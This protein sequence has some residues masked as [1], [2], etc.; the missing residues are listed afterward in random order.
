M[1]YRRNVYMYYYYYVEAYA[2]VTGRVSTDVR[3]GRFS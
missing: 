2:A 1:A 3:P